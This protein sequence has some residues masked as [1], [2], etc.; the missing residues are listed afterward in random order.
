MARNK[1]NEAG[2]FNML[3]GIDRA[4][5]SEAYKKYDLPTFNKEG[6]T[7]EEPPVKG[8]K[9]KAY[10]EAI[11]A[12]VY[13]Y[14]KRTNYKTPH[15]PG[16]TIDDLGRQ[17]NCIHGVCQIVEGTGAKKFSQEYFGNM[18]F[19]DNM[20]KEGFYYAQPETEGFEI[21]DFLRFAR[22]KGNEN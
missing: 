14:L 15:V 4:I 9:K 5:K 21:G 20:K 2:M 3:T 10:Q 6:N 7:G 16:K 8:A 17:M 19:D 12:N 1:F 18:V 22:T 11:T 13:D